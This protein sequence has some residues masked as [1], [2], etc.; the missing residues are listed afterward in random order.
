L[1]GIKMLGCL[2]YSLDKINTTLANTSCLPFD[3][4]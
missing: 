3:I 1:L 4:Q 2:L